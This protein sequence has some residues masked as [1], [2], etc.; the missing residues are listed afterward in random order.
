MRTKGR[1]NADWGFR[2]PTPGWHSVVVLEGVDVLTNEKS[3]KQ[4]LM[5]PLNI[6]EGSADD[7]I[8]VSIFCPYKD[9]NGDYSEFGEQKAADFLQAIGLAEKF[10]EKFPGDISLF[11][12]EPL[13]ALKLKLPGRP[14]K[15]KLELSSDGKYTNVVGVKDISAATEEPKA[16][17]AQKGK[18]ATTAKSAPAPAAKPVEW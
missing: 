6:E 1:E 17:T 13:N 5:I 11:D 15:V 14:A 18:G 3:G 10:E 2:V 4:S 16:A 8:R 9:E 7:G 12:T